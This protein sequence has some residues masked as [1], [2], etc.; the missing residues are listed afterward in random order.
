VRVKLYQH[1]GELYVFAK[2][3]GR[4]GEGERDAQ[5]SLPKCDHF[6]FR[7]SPGKKEAGRAVG[8]VKNGI[9]RDPSMCESARTRR[10][11]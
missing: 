5:Q 2:T 10:L 9:G 6:L 11:K 1:D 8:F 4:Q 7:I 3:D